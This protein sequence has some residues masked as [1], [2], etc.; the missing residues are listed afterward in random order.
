MLRIGDVT[1]ALDELYPPGWAESWDAVGL[2]VGDPEAP[3][4]RILLAVDPVE[5]V[6]D[7]A[8]RGGFD[9]LVTHHPLLL[10]GVHSVARTTPKGRVVHELI[11]SGTGLFVAHT[12][13]DV[14]LPGVSDALATAIGL[15][16][17]RPLD[18]AVG[19]ARDKLVCFVP[20]EHRDQLVDALAAAGAGRIGEYERCAWSVDGEGTFRPL[21]GANP[22]V[23]EVGA[24]EQVAEARVEMVFPRRIRSAIIVALR[25]SHPYEE[26]AYD[27]YELADL[28]NGRGLGRIGELPT[29]TR[30]ADFAATVAAALPAAPVGVRG[31]GDPDRMIRTVAV[32]GG[33]GDSQLGTATRAGVDAYVTA[34]LRHHPAAEHL[35]AAGPALLDVGHWA[36]EWPWL[37]DCAGRL[38]TGLGGA[39]VETVVSTQVTDP[40]TL[41]S[42]GAA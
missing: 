3:V 20:T 41:H 28:P 38:V 10:R 39:T 2:V 24:V 13:A 27:V 40:W 42:T 11:R 5:S 37:T 22:T 6:V 14:A 17:L 30:F 12:N 33:A 31:A 32:C 8:V 4:G 34:D 21:D 36:S 18:A 29:A 35:E 16:S 25:D 7:E 1:R 19:E 15:T 9:L 23:G 26:P